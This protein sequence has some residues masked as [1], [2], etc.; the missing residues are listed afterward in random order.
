MHHALAFKPFRMYELKQHDSPIMNPNASML[1]WHEKA[2]SPDG[3]VNSDP[4]CNSLALTATRGATNR[5]HSPRRSEIY[6]FTSDQDAVLATTDTTSGVLA[7]A[8]T[9]NVGKLNSLR[10]LLVNMVVFRVAETSVGAVGV[11][12]ISGVQI[13]QVC[14][15]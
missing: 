8:G 5:A 12:V 4:G 13:W 15:W 10:V 7:V 14:F 3:L 11:P 1:D 2:L 6:K 9:R